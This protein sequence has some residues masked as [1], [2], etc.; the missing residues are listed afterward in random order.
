MMPSSKSHLRLFVFP[1]LIA[2][3][4]LVPKLFLD[5]RIFCV[6]F[7]GATTTTSRPIVLLHPGIGHARNY[8][9]YHHLLLSKNQDDG[10]DIDLRNTNQ[11]RSL[12]NV[13]SSSSSSSSTSKQFANSKSPESKTRPAASTPLDNLNLV[14][15]TASS[16]NSRRWFSSSWYVWK[17]GIPNYI[18]CLRLLIIPV[19]AA[20]FFMAPI[21]TPAWFAVATV[22]DFF[23][24]YLARK[25]QVASDFGAF[26]DPVADK[27][28]VS[29]CLILL[30]SKYGMIVAA[31]TAVIVAREIAVSALREWMAQRNLRNTVKVSWQGKLKTACTMVALFVMLLATASDL[32]VSSLWYTSLTLLY[33][34]AALTVSSGAAYFRAA[35]P[36]LLQPA[37]LPK[38]L[39][40]KQ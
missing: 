1:V 30:T 13:S 16:H 26:L 28:L 23:D 22:S 19:V 14:A 27:L 37:P 4:F 32:G 10:E 11:T 17:T 25:W 9:S 8:R 36:T 18:T 33:V 34:S 31:P 20:S 2:L 29:T 40:K 38:R 6:G 3:I 7:R 39:V 5:T 15:G 12:P 24:G 35:A 21:W